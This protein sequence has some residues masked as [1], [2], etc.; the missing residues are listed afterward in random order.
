[1]DKPVV[2]GDVKH[3][4]KRTPRSGE[5]VTVVEIM[6]WMGKWETE[7]DGKKKIMREVTGNSE[8]KNKNT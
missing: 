6:K 1:M 7:I 8:L 3:E 4:E 5:R 2:F